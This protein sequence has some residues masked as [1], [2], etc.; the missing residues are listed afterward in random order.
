VSKK[1]KKKKSPYIRMV[2]NL[3]DFVIRTAEKENP[4]PAEINAMTEAAKLL[5]K[6]I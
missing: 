6:T 2:L 1:K 5:F 4:T 3:S